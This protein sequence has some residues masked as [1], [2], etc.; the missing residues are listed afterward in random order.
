MGRSEAETHHTIYR[1]RSKGECSETL[2]TL[3][4]NAIK[5][6]A[7]TQICPISTYS[8]AVVANL[9]VRPGLT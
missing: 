4:F 6:R 7:D 8:E 3:G 2:P 9:R 1:S 5:L